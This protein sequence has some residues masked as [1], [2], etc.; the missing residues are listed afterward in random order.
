VG[1]NAGSFDRSPPKFCRFAE[2]GRF[3][4]DGSLSGRAV[5]NGLSHGL[6]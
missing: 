6:I 2:V 1:L 3:L 4:L 5:P